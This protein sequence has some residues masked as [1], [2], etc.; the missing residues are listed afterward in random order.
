[1][2]KYCL[3]TPQ[4][5]TA[6]VIQEDEEETPHTPD[7]HNAHDAH[8]IHEHEHE[9]REETP[10]PQ[11]TEEAPE[12]SV[13]PNGSQYNSGNDEFPLD[14]FNEY[15][16]VEESDG[17][18]NVVYIHT[19]REMN[20]SQMKDLMSLS[21]T[22]VSEDPNMTVMDNISIMNPV[23]PMD[24]NPLELLVNL[25]KDRCLKV[26]YQCRDKE[27]GMGMGMDTVGMGMSKA[28]GE[29]EQAWHQWTRNVHGTG[30]MGMGTAPVERERERERHW[31]NGNR[32][33]NSAVGNWYDGAV[34]IEYWHGSSSKTL[35]VHIQ[36]PGKLFLIF[37]HTQT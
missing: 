35:L 19:I 31:Q 10:A 34:G 9:E 2:S 1:M 15:I 5:F 37:Y 36:G 4:V 30:G 25:P 7:N 26:Y 3:N 21:N 12:H 24:L 20:P 18:S 11:E 32:H 6:Q 27:D 13:D 8:E 29:W 28:T 33:G 17:D 22:G 14:A 16:E 23:V